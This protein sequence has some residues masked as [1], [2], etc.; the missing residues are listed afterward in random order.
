MHFGVT[1]PADTT[2]VVEALEDSQMTLAS[3]SANRYATPFR[4]ELTSWLSKLAS[5]SEQV[6]PP[7]HLHD[8]GSTTRIVA[9]LWETRIQ[10][11]ISAIAPPCTGLHLREMAACMNAKNLKCSPTS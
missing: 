8:L 4:E 6:T 1:Q 10:N 11:F 7:G 5:V 9:H 3:L 2:E